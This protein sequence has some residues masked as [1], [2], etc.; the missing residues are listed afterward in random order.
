MTRKNKVYENVEAP[1]VSGR[2]WGSYPAG[3]RLLHAVVV[4]M[5]IPVSTPWHRA[6]DEKQDGNEL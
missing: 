6:P 5:L 4:V 1:V 2:Y 3:G